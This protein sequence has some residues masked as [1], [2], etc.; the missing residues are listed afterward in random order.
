MRKKVAESATTASGELLV[1]Q[2]TTSRASQTWAM[3]IKQVYEVDP[4]KCQRCICLASQ[5]FRR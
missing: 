5:L 3:L 1:D 2:P 4:L